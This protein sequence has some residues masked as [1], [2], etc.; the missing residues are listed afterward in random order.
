M[1]RRVWSR[2]RGSIDLSRLLKSRWRAHSP[3]LRRPTWLTV[4][5]AGLLLGFF[6][7]AFSVFAWL[8]PRPLPSE[9][10]GFFPNGGAPLELRAED[11]LGN[12]PTALRLFDPEDI[13]TSDRYTK[14]PGFLA[15]CDA[16]R[17]IP[18]SGVY[19]CV[20]ST[21]L[22]PGAAV[23]DPCFGLN[24]DEVV[25]AVYGGLY[26]GYQVPNGGIVAYEP[27]VRSLSSM[28]P[29][30]L[31]LR[32]GRTCLW[33]WFSADRGV[34]KQDLWLCDSEGTTGARIVIPTYQDHMFEFSG[35]GRATRGKLIAYDAVFSITMPADHG[36]D[37]RQPA[38]AP[39]TVLMRLHGDEQVFEHAVV[40]EAWY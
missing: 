22:T 36:I 18:L 38:D 5:A 17:A 7:L 35:Q 8:R 1:S 37:L 11:L 3:R 32:D 31:R 21:G 10:R 29:W 15:D 2:A 9:E 6:G 25:C 19:N 39:W 14:L 30:R 24:S 13:L 12:R 28:Y 33:D 4:T 23:H 26:W 34:V 27:T 40:E 16:S 20:S